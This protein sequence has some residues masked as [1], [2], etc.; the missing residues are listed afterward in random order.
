MR[1][2]DGALAY[3][4]DQER[5]G[6]TAWAG[7]CEKLARSAYGLPAHY[8]SANVHANA[9]PAAF[10]HGHEQPRAGDLVLYL[11]STYGH[12]VV[13]T[14]NGWEVY[15]NDYGGRGKVTR[16]DARNLVSWCGASSWFVAD[17]WWST[18]NVQHTHTTP[19]DDMSLTDDDVDRIARAVWAY[20][21]KGQNRDQAQVLADARTLSEN[22]PA[23]TW[24][25]K[26]AGQARDAYQVLRDIDT[27]TS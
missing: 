19:E 18:S 23:R 8:S 27:H 24:G 13:A 12:I 5:S 22:G 4:R 14:G 25:Y 26:G 3:L 11:N 20:T 7:L 21:V 10:R 16:T 6:S 1:T 2:P 17:A 15:T 9:I